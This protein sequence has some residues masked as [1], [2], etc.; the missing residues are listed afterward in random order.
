MAYEHCNAVN[1]SWIVTPYPIRV[2]V[3][4]SKL[5]DD[6]SNV[7]WLLSHVHDVVNL[8]QSSS[9]Q[10]GSVWH[11]NVNTGYSVDRRVQVVECLRWRKTPSTIYYIVSVGV[12]INNY[13]LTFHDLC[14]NFSANASKRPALFHGDHVIRFH[15]APFDRLKIERPQRSQINHL[16]IEDSLFKGVF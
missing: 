13:Q 9:L 14:Y 7:E 2:S 10:M 4:G 5:S 1:T 15:H 3:S 16:Q 11:R 6:S 12:E 8:R